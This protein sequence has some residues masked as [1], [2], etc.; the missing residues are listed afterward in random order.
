MSIFVCVIFFYW[1]PGLT[2][3]TGPLR[4]TPVMQI[5]PPAALRGAHVTCVVSR[6]SQ[7]AARL[8][9][10]TCVADGVVRVGVRGGAADTDVITSCGQN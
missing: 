5:L 4:V 2:I 7:T 6:A 3:S 1:Y 8:G 9:A 10:L